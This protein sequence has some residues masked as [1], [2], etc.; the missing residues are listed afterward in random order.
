LEADYRLRLA[1][2]QEEQTLTAWHEWLASFPIKALQQR[3][4]ISTTG[5]R[6]QQILELLRFFGV[7]SVPA[8]RTRCAELMEADFRTSP[9]FAS[10]FEALVTW[11]RVGELK[12]A[13]INAKDYNRSLFLE[14][15]RRIRP[16]TRCPVPTAIPVIQ[17][18]CAEA[19]VCFV[20]EKPFDKVSASGVS[21]WL[22][23]NC[24]LIQQSFRYGSDDHFW[25]TF[26]HEAAHLLLHS[27]KS[28]YID[29]PKGTGNAEP[30]QER[31]A[32]EW[33][34][35]FLVPQNE[36]MRFMMH[37]KGRYSEGDIIS[38]AEAC[39]IAPG[40][41]VGQLQH[42]GALSFSR[43]NDLKKRYDWCDI[44]RAVS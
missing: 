20:I 16:L 5:D 17:E 3:R 18:Y 30:H 41:V 27:R 19:G 24:A 43:L 22:S 6:S 44:E 11:L 40:I 39:D 10:S 1:R 42:R 38:F 23:T 4:L 2:E 33:A 29:E 12:A 28:L 13:E 35:E 25:F 7:G 8:F 26:F 32:N 21:R 36:L 9:T 34:A 37:S 14:A 31:E 15:L